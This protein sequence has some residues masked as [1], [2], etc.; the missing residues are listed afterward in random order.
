MAVFVEN[1]T[2]KGTYGFSAYNGWREG[3]RQGGCVY[4]KGREG[5]DQFPVFGNEWI[6]AL[7]NIGG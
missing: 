2:S 3:R 4:I 5:E 1:F 6:F 7:K